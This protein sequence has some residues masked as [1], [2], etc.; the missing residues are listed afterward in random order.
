M[1]NCTVCNRQLR[2]DT[3]ARHMKRHGPRSECTVCGRMVRED[4][5]GR[6]MELHAV[7]TGVTVSRCTRCNKM[8][9]NTE[10][11][12]GCRPASFEWRG[13]EGEEGGHVEIDWEML[14]SLYGR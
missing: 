5:L 4:D 1:V 14:D 13:P 7:A 6:H 12:H 11:D 3:L 9:R 2:A 8:V 10:T